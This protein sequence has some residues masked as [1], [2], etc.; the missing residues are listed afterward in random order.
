MLRIRRRELRRDDERALLAV[1][2]LGELIRDPRM[3][4]P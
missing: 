2:E 4:E 3:T 1:Q